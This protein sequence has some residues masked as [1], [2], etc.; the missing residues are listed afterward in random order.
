MTYRDLCMSKLPITTAI[1]SAMSWSSTS[2]QYAFSLT[3]S[4][5]CFTA[6]MGRGRQSFSKS[7]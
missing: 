5:A 6:V 1:N 4:E 3:A 7:A 2:A